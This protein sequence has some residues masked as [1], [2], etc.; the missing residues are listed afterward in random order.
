MARQP[1]DH[2]LET[3]EAR[4]KLAPRKEPYWRQ[5]IPG[6][7][8][9]YYRGA[10][11]SAWLVRQRA[12]DRYRAQRIGTPD[13]H[14]NADGDVV[15]SYSQAVKLATATQLEE[16]TPRPRHYGDGL[17][18]DALLSVYFDA[19]LAGRGSEKIARQS[20]ARH[21]GAIGPRLVTALSADALR[22]W[23]R[24]LAAKPP[25]VRGKV[26]PFDPA[27]QDQVRSRK[28][29]ANRV[30][31][32]VK[33]ALNFA[34]REDKLPADVSPFWQK[35]EP[36]TLGDD[37][38][39]RMLEQAEI[40]RLINACPPD[41]RDLV[42]GALMTGYRYSEGRRLLV[43]DFSPD[44][45]T[46]RIYQ[47]KTGKTLL[48]PLTPEGVKFFERVTSGRAPTETIFVR[49]DGRQWSQSDVQKPMKAAA[50]A[51]SLDDISF[52]VTRATYGKLLLLATRDIELVAKAL[53]H[54]DSRITRKHYAQYLPSEVAAGVAMM[55]S[56][57]ITQDGKISRIRE[58]RRTG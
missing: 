14:A 27:D 33:A 53:G 24:D 8:L 4:F 52:K 13:D 47:S 54:S 18:L 10:R 41:L 56:L 11:G 44:H 5:I 58:K 17:T 31:T 30:L 21:A 38:L 51:A 46:I 23:H 25:T 35:V 19:V 6:T 36:F 34:W 16:R 32:I 1:R 43:R 49:A 42:T 37:P 9:G 2:R 12:G 22:K 3:R 28:A 40:T 39:P 55:P 45:G 15:L 29:T 57:G 26:Q 48:Q 50:A 7:F 20:Y